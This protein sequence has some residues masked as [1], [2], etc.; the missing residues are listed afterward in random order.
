MIYKILLNG[1]IIHDIHIDKLKIFNP[2]VN[3]EQNK[4]G[5]FE[6]TIYSNHPFYN[7]VKELTSILTVYQNDTIIFK[8]RVIELTTNTNKSLNVYCESS[9]AYLYDTIQK[10]YE[11]K[12]SVKG[13]LEKFIDEHNSAVSDDKKFIVGNVTVTDP[14]DYI[15]RSNSDYSTTWN[16]INTKL[17]NVLGGYLVVRYEN[18]GMYLD[19]L[20]DFTTLN[21]QYVEFGKNILSVKFDKDYSSVA[22]VLIPLGS[23]N[24]ETGER[25]TIESVNDGKNY[26]ENAEAVAKY[27]RIVKTQTWDDVTLPQNLLTKGNNYL[28]SIGSVSTVIQISAIDMANINK[29]ISNFKM[30]SKIK[31]KSKYH[32]ID[33]YFIPLKMTIDLFNQKNNKITLNGEKLT[34]TEND[35][36]L[37][38]I[39]ETVEN[40]VNNYQ[41]NIP[42]R[43]IELKKELTSAIEQTSTQ[44]K[45]E[46]S[47]KY[48]SKDDKA[49]LIAEINTVFEQSSQYFEMQFNS[50]QQDL[51]DLQEGT[52][53]NFEDI[54][55]YVRFENGNILLG[56]IGNEF[57]LKITKER[58]SFMQGEIEVAYVSNSKLY[59]TYVD[60]L[61]SLTIGNFAFIP[62]TSGNL[63]FKKVNS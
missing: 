33:Q 26:I 59:N 56:Q 31:V 25:L 14:N 41:V 7:A 44:I 12:G 45:S 22:T 29:D 21:S 58:I 13:L 16:A 5:S 1:D 8:G 37:G 23:K 27:G 60:V 61:T 20:E 35:G 55:K 57:S 32:D 43:I 48:Y 39:A 38:A 9:E 36:G 40:I 18:D 30:Y 17:V 51:N 15:V 3:L 46:V 11:Y 6:F 34:L 47:E 19:Y 53:A 62:R 52:N 28:A 50:F 24:E 10:P 4:I 49:D 42:N 54:R 63:S 2:K